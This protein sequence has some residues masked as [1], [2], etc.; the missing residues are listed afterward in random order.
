VISNAY[1]KIDF[2][3]IENALEEISTQEG[4]GDLS[5]SIIGL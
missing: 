4:K 1:P 5:R 2:L 3:T